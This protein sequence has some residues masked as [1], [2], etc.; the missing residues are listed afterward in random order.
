MHSPQC[1]RPEEQPLDSTARFAL[2]AA[3]LGEAESEL[4]RVLCLNHG[5]WPYSLMV[6]VCV[7]YVACCVL[8]VLDVSNNDLDDIPSCVGCIVSLRRLLI[9]GN[10]I[11]KIRRSVCVF[12]ICLFLLLRRLTRVALC[13]VCVSRSPLEP[14][15]RGSQKA[16]PLSSY[17]AAGFLT[18]HFS[19]MVLFTL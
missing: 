2:S 19:M 5:L 15:S 18:F 4:P 13:C 3:S 16:S 11:K 9:D 12:F 8:Q 17:R 14:G 1:D 7:L 10:P 6:W